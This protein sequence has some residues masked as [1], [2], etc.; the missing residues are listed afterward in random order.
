M[1][2]KF[3]KRFWAWI[4]LGIGLAFGLLAAVIGGQ[5]RK[6]GLP[7]TP[8]RPQ[9]P[10]VKVPDVDTSP[11]DDYAAGKEP[12]TTDTGSVVD[13]INARHR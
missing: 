7:D 4:V 2:I 11:A 9:L 10:D 6:P 12:V 13:E 1:I 8:A 3:L 5:R